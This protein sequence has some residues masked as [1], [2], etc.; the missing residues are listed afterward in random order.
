MLAGLIAGP[1]QSSG[2][3]DF[4]GFDKPCA[5][6]GGIYRALMPQGDGPFPAM[7]YLYG[8]G[9]KSAEIANHPLFHAAVVQ[10]GYA[11][12][13]PA[14]ETMQYR[15]DYADSGWALRHEAAPGPGR[16]DVLFL[17]RV[18]DDAA[19][20]F[21]VD[22]DRILLVGQ[23]RGAFL[24]WEIACHE[25][26]VAAGYA[27]HAG[28]Y[29]GP[30]PQTCTRPV[31]FLHTHGMDD[32]LVPIAG[33]VAS[34]GVTMAPVQSSLDVLAR[35]DGCNPV[36][37]DAGLMLGFLRTHWTGCKGGS[38]LDLLLHPGGHM[39]PSECFRAVIDWFEE[40]PEATPEVAPHTVAAGT[41]A[42]ERFKAVPT[43]GGLLSAP[44]TSGEAEAAPA[45]AGQ[46]LRPPKPSRQASQ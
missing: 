8:S 29:L 42:G 21:G 7:V 27:V 9:G 6:Q 43:A 20:R 18:L 31:R 23:S 32:P 24:I 34:G 30:M 46:R 35:T 1:A 11:L 45:P 36:P 26:G 44:S 19:S 25:P 10:R 15:P 38:S 2:K 41:A 40:T 33:L 12:I 16:D 4:S 28:G 39:M 17:R 37:E 22:R 14:A 13:V 3:C 5:V